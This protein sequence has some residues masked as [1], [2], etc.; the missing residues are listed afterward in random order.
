MKYFSLFFFASAVTFCVLAQSNLLNAKMVDEIGLKT[1][2]E[3]EKD[4]DKPL[5]Y[6]YVGDRDVLMGRIVWEIIDLDERQNFHM[7]YPVEEDMGSHRKALFEVLAKGME[8]GRITEVFADSYFTRKKSLKEIQS[9]RVFLDTTN[10]GRDQLFNEGFV[11]PMYIDEYRIEPFHVSDYKIKGMW[12]F[13][14]RQGDMRYRML[15]IC[16]VTPD[17]YT[18]T[19]P[20]ATDYV[21]LFWVFL[22]DAREVLHENKAFNDRN[23]QNSLTYDHILNARK[24]SSRIYKEQ[25]VMQD[26]EVAAYMKENALNQL[27]EGDRIREKLRNFEIDMWNY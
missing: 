18:L 17:V 3:I 24:F 5:E 4:N 9:A 6:G 25:N 27:L 10:A 23:P 20:D 14:K 21:E 7:Y 8:D 19:N 26:R 22:P 13:D 15:G 11:D 2:Q 12:Y 16:P 1:L